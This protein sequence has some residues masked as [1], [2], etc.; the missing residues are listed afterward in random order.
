MTEENAGNLLA[1]QTG[2]STSA[3]NAILSGIVSEALNHEDIEEIYGAHFGFEGL[4]KEQLIDLAEESQQAIRGMRYTPHAALGTSLRLLESQGDLDRAVEV[5]KVHRI[6]YLVGIADTQ[7]IPSFKALAEA[8]EQSG[9]KLY[10]ILIPHSSDNSVPVTDHSCGYGSA[11]KTIASRVKQL[12][13]KLQ[14]QT[15]SKRVAIMEIQDTNSGWLVAG[16][17]LAKSRNRPEDPPHLLFFP[18]IPFSHQEALSE[19]EATLKKQSYLTIVCSQSLFDTEGNVLGGGNDPQ[20]ESAGAYLQYHIHNQFGIQP[21]RHLISPED[22]IN[23]QCLSEYDIEE[24]MRAG[25]EATQAVVKEKSGKMLTMMNAEN[26]TDAGKSVFTDF[27]DIPDESK[28]LP[29]EWIHENGTSLR[30]QFVKYA[31]RFIEGEIHP[32]HENGLPQFISLHHHRVKRE[33]ET[34]R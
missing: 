6:Q 5:L 22:R 13:L 28:Q 19:M 27:K 4:L 14:E 16:S 17:S 29:R 9:H 30:H 23:G 11:C 24:A 12:S 10:V 20:V 34:M 31:Q 15:G 32:P 7:T 21:T 25:R 8:A 33:L 1:I 3:T 2:Q 26:D 18:E